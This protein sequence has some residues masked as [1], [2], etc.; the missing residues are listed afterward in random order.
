MLKQAQTGTVIPFKRI[1][2]TGPPIAEETPSGFHTPTEATRL[3]RV[4]RSVLDAWREGIVRPTMRW[5]DEDGREH[6][7][8][9]FEDVVCVRLLRMLRDQGISLEKAVNAVNELPKRFGPP[10]RRWEHARIFAQNRDAF[11]YREDEWRTTIATRKG[12]KVADELFGEQF[13]SLRERAD[14]LLVPK[15]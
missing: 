1:E 12:Q 15:A 2:V 4:R 6:F 8:H 5:V 11:V 13:G 14:A 9:G 7:G 3:A 10:G